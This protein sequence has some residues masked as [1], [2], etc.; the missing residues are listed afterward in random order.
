[1]LVMYRILFQSPWLFL[2]SL[3]GCNRALIVAMMDGWAKCLEVGN[4]EPTDEAPALTLI[5]HLWWQ[6]ESP[7]LV[8]AGN[9]IGTYYAGDPEVYF[10]KERNERHLDFHALGYPQN[11]GTTSPAFAMAFLC[12][13]LGYLSHDVRHRVLEVWLWRAHTS[14]PQQ[15]LR[16]KT[17]VESLSQ[18]ICKLIHSGWYVQLPETLKTLESLDDLLVIRERF[19]DRL[20]TSRVPRSPVTGHLSWTRRH[21]LALPD[22]FQGT[23]T[24]SNQGGTEQWYQFQ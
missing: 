9:I 16:S 22:Q 21:Q 7:Y 3:R 10:K 24:T 4:P 23:M 14:Q 19:V 8:E 11:W 1:M 13:E 20:R 18:T 5:N 12:P 6:I 2:T 17:F 15:W